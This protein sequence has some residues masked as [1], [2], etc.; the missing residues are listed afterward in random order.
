[1]YTSNIGIQYIIIFVYGNVFEKYLLSCLVD[2]HHIGLL[3]NGRIIHFAGSLKVF[4]KSL[5]EDSYLVI[6]LKS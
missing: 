1:M 5:W 6:A 2:V 4:P 3:D